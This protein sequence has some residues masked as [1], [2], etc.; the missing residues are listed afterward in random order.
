MRKH[1]IKDSKQLETS[2]TPAHTS[3]DEVI[4]RDE[5]N[6]ESSLRKRNDNEFKLS[7]RTGLLSASH[8]TEQLRENYSRLSITAS[9]SFIEFDEKGNTA[10]KQY[11]PPSPHRATFPSQKLSPE[12]PLSPNKDKQI[13]LEFSQFSTIF[14]SKMEE[15][16]KKIELTVPSLSQDYIIIAPNL[17]MTNKINDMMKIACIKA[18]ESVKGHIF[19]PHICLKSGKYYPWDF[20]KKV[21]SVTPFNGVCAFVIT[22]DSATNLLSLRIGTTG[23]FYLAINEDDMDARIIQYKKANRIEILKSSDYKFIDFEGIKQDDVVMAGD[24]YFNDGI[25]EAIILKSGCFQVDLNINTIAMSA[26]EF[27]VG[28]PYLS[29][30]ENDQFELMM[31]DIQALS[32]I[33]TSLNS[34]QEKKYSELIQQ[35]DKLLERRVPDFQSITSEKINSV[36][37]K[38]F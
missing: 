18:R 12:K 13:K 35:R 31:K 21:L 34:E 38:L 10:K 8:S 14:D 15:V 29:W 17:K 30:Q 3:N 4:A 2:P 28:K 23:H 26:F 11:K 33:Q 24:L 16:A 32:H 6:L 20:Q 37:K 1:D 22:H 25:L 27:L 36:R 7:E 9:K 19:H 5:T